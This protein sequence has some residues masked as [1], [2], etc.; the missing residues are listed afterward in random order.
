MSRYDLTPY[1]RDAIW[2]VA[3]PVRYAGTRFDARTAVI[4]LASGG[5]VLHSPGPIEAGLRERIDALGTVRAILA[6]SN[7][8]HLHVTAAQRAFPE[9]ATFLCPGLEKKRADLKHDGVLGDEPHPLWAADLDQV[10]QR[11]NRVTREVACLHRASRTVLLVD[12]VENFTSVTPGLSELL[13][14]WM[15]VFRMWNRPRPAP[16]IQLFTRDGRALRESLE[17]VLAWQPERVVL[18]HG[19]LIEHDVEATL[20][21]AWD[22]W[23]RE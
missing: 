23:L 6:P 21:R 15:R 13:K 12:L 7:F 16:E 19:E 4:R 18:A 9:A 14:L 2:L 20:R 17:R 10:V 1:V 3:Y 22:R 8:H 5:L 11:G